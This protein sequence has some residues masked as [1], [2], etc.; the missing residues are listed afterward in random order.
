MASQNTALTAKTAYSQH[1]PQHGAE[2]CERLCEGQEGRPVGGDE[3]GRCNLQEQKEQAGRSPI[4]LTNSGFFHG[5]SLQ[6]L[7]RPRN[8]GAAGLS[9]SR[10]Q[11]QS[12]ISVNLI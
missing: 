6:Y 9:P 11:G 5:N 3:A 7:W 2:A 10:R 12:A 1:Q 8:S 4:P